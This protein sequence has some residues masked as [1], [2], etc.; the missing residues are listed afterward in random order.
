LGGDVARSEERGASR[1]YSRSPPPLAAPTTT[2]VAPTAS[3]PG[4]SSGTSNNTDKEDWRKYL[5][6][7][8]EEPPASREG[9][10]GGV[11][12]VGM[13]TGAATGGSASVD[14]RDEL[15]QAG[16]KAVPTRTL[17]GE[18]MAT[19]RSGQGLDGLD[20]TSYSSTEMEAYW[21]RLF[22]SGDIDGDGELNREELHQLLTLNSDFHL[23]AESIEELLETCDADGSGTID[24]GEFCEMMTLYGESVKAVRQDRQG[25]QP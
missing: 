1:D 8:N 11:G 5:K 20:M 13:E 10:E 25:S 18:G 15:M 7:S 14:L 3:S 24:F 23:N 19:R 16:R 12:G 4:S 2:A 17:G 9:G 6:K 21:T 22:A